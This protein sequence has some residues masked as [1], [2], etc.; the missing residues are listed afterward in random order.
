[1][2]SSALDYPPLHTLRT[3]TY[4][5]SATTLEARLRL[6]CRGS[7]CAFRAR[8]ARLILHRHIPETRERKRKNKIKVQTCVAKKMPRPDEQCL[9]ISKFVERKPRVKIQKH[10]RYFVAEVGKF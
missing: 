3:C 8:P 2:F 9:I 7:V 5:R 10:L 1:M 6:P 4:H